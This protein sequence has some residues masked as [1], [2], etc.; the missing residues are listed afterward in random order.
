MVLKKQGEV[1]DIWRKTGVSMTKVNVY[2]KECGT[3]NK[4][5]GGELW[6][7]I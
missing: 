4:D 7:R 5:D 2:G 1:F 3:W 6:E